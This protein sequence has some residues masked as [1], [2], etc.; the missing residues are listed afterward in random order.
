[1]D[2]LKV[3][4]DQKEHKK[5]F[6]ELLSD[7]EPEERREVKR[8]GSNVSLSRYRSCPQLLDELDF[9]A[10]SFETTADDSIQQLVAKLSPHNQAPLIRR[11][12]QFDQNGIPGSATPTPPSTPRSR[13]SF[14][15]QKDSPSTPIQGSSPVST[16]RLF[17]RAFIHRPS[18]SR[19]SSADSATYDNRSGVL[20]DPRNN[21]HSQ[22]LL[23]EENLKKHEQT[24]LTSPAK[25]V[26]RRE[27]SGTGDGRNIQ[28]HTYINTSDVTSGPNTDS[29]QDKCEKWL[30]T[31]HLSKP[32]KI[33]SR[34]HIQLPP[35]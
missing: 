13:R 20:S 27:S 2:T 1:M 29:S 14:F 9:S 15:S 18:L 35:V 17:H 3:S 26:R 4:S 10:Q 7:E 23:N 6:A 16:P 31:L 34:S 5:V 33:K 21:S 11:Q 22:V 19:E 30:Q 28:H 8:R 24:N 25:I 32:D 12:F